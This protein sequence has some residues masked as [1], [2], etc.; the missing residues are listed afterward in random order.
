[1][2]CESYIALKTFANRV[3][4]MSYVEAGLMCSFV[5]IVLYFCFYNT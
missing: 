2:K 3:C 5:C 4:S 1:L